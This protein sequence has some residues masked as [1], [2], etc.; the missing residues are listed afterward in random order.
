MLA[1]YDNPNVM[2]PYYQLREN[3]KK[4][5][6]FLHQLMTKELGITAWFPDN[7]SNF[8]FETNPHPS[9]Y[10]YKDIKIK[11]DKDFLCCLMKLQ[12]HKC[13]AFCMQKRRIV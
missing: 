5:E 13:S 11:K 2:Q 9:K 7:V 12:Y 3:K 4:Q 8:N 1:I 10:L 6:E